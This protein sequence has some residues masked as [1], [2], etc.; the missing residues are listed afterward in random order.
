M[1]TGRFL[2]GKQYVKGTLP[3]SHFRYCC[4]ATVARCYLPLRYC[5]EFWNALI[6]KISILA[7]CLVLRT[8]TTVPPMAGR[9]IVAFR[10]LTLL[11]DDGRRFRC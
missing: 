7:Q 8:I 9:F 5:L 11:T 1:E 10:S 4:Y 3:T 6:V 2:L